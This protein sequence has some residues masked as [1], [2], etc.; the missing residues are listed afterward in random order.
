M[1]NHQMRRKER[2]MPNPEAL[3]LLARG[4]YGVLS[5]CDGNGQVYGVPL[6]YANTATKIY[7][8][9][10]QTGHKL[11]NILYHPEV[12]FTVVG[13]TKVLPKKFS[14]AF[15]SVIVF[16]EAQLISDR[17]EKRKALNLLAWKYAPEF[18]EE[19]EAYIDRAIDHTTVVGITI[20]H[21]TGKKREELD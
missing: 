11:E 12:C 1:H 9:S 8:H 21:Y 2:Q 7:F 4:E 5:T 14:T 19:G 18:P 15:E 20:R 6:S 17:E 16:G 3:S 10:A 13:K